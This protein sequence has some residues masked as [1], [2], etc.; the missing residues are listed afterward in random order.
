MKNDLSERLLRFSVDIFLF[1]KTIPHNVENNVIRYQLA[2][3]STSAG[4]NYEE[5][6]AGSTRPDFNAKVDIALKEM[7]ESNYWLKLLDALKIG[8]LDLLKKLLKESHELKLILGSIASK[9]SK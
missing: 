9:T 6:Q 1:L 7:R 3:S 8:D 4:A 2:K 5:A